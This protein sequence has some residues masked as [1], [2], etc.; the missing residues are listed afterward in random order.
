M[1]DSGALPCS[2]VR[3]TSSKHQGNPIWPVFVSVSCF[4][5][6]VTGTNEAPVPKTQHEQHDITRELGSHSRPQAC[7]E[8]CM[9]LATAVLVS[10]GATHGGAL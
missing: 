7:M 1:L 3:A 4:L 9:T 2:G 10:M 5:S 8:A 6:R